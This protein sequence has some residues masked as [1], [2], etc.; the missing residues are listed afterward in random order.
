MPAERPL[1]ELAA[2]TTRFE[3]GRH[4]V[5]VTRVQEGRWR[6]GVDGADLQGTSRTQAEAW[7]VGVR[8]AARLDEKK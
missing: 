6:V 8:E 5:A 2:I 7:E 3:V 1:D 4:T